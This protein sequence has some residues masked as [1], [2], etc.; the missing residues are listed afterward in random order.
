MLLFGSL[1]LL[2]LPVPLIAASALAMFLLVLAS[3]SVL[4]CRICCQGLASDFMLRS[5]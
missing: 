3:S 5:S 4:L 2:I 1:L